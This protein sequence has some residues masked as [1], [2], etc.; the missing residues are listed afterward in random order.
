MGRVRAIAFRGN[1]W[2]V[3]FLFLKWDYKTRIILNFSYHN[4]LNFITKQPA[5][6]EGLLSGAYSQNVVYMFWGLASE[7]DRNTH[8]TH[9]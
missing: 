6:V 9:S 1:A 2:A 5:L 8:V 3:A 7:T 4:N